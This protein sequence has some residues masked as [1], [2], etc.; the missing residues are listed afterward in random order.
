M[1][2]SIEP[3]PF[4]YKRILCDYK[5][6][7]KKILQDCDSNGKQS[8][9]FSDKYS[10]MNKIHGSNTLSLHKESQEY[11]MPHICR[12]LTLLFSDLFSRLPTT[13]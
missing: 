8:L 9:Q 2:L 3:K 6:Q 5:R 10:T 7:L 1:E 11:H 4:N 13:L 12:L